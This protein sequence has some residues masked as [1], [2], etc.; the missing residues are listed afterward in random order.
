MRRYLL[1][2]WAEFTEE[3]IVGFPMYVRRYLLNIFFPRTNVTEEVLAMIVW[4]IVV[5]K[6]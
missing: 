2:Y 6:A 1:N 4:T 5:S 3:V